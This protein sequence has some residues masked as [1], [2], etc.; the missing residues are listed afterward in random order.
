[1]ERS[2]WEIIALDRKTQNMVLWSD[3]VEYKTKLNENALEQ[4]YQRLQLNGTRTDFERNPAFFQR[5]IDEKIEMYANNNRRAETKIIYDTKTNVGVCVKTEKY[6]RQPN[7]PIIEWAMDNYG[8]INEK[9]SH[10]SDYG[11]KLVVG[12]KDKS[13]RTYDKDDFIAGVNFRNSESGN[14]GL[15]ASQ[16]ITRVRCTNGWVTRRN[17]NM[18]KIAHIYPDLLKRLEHAMVDLGDISNLIPILNKSKQKPYVIESVEEMSTRLKQISVPT[19]YHEPIKEAFNTEPLGMDSEGR[20]N[21]W[22]IFNAITRYISHG[23]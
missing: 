11:M 13:F 6:I 23:F 4:A 7:L 12:G 5:A 9:A 17:L 19:R 8:D 3:N 15:G 18:V 10:I 2:H 16:H 21:D 20:I 1:M 22:G 14:G